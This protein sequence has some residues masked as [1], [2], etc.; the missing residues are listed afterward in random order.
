MS[1]SIL[2]SLT[3]LI[4]NKFRTLFFRSL[5]KGFFF[6]FGILD[7][8]FEPTFIKISL[9]VS[10]MEVLFAI[11][12]LSTNRECGGVL[13]LD[14]SITTD[15]IPFQVFLDFLNFFENNFDDTVFS[16]LLF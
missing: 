4:K 7:T 5:P 8:R 1:S 2:V 6:A 16:I 11:I 3:G 12:I 9:N 10:T 14:F 15:F 13:V